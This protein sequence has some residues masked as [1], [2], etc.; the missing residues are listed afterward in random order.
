MDKGSRKSLKKRSLLWILGIILFINL[1]IV[2]T[3]N[4]HIYKAVFYNFADIDDNTIFYSRKVEAG[5]PIEWP[6]SKNYNKILM[7]SFLE[8]EHK[9]N[10]SVAFLIIKD[11]S[12]R[13]EKYWEGYD[14]NSLS[15]SFSMAKTIVSILVGIAIDEGKI[16]SLDEPV[17]NYLEEFK[18]GG[19]EVI[20]IRNLLTMSSGLNWDESYSNPFSVTTKAYYG[21]NLRKL[22]SKLE[23]IEDPGKV[24]KYLSGNSQILA[25]V[26]EKAT[27]MKLSKYASEKLW[28]P[29]GARNSA[30]WSL[31]KKEGEEKAYC[32]FYS[33]A[34]DFAKI[35]QLFLKKGNWYGQQMVSEQYVLESITPAALSQDDGTPNDYYGY[36][37]WIIPNY[38]NQKIYY[39]RGIL[40]QYIIVVPDKEMIIVRLGKNRGEKRG[41]HYSDLFSYIDGALE[42]YP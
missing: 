38:K 4:T 3:A 40:G 2:I 26:L 24:I 13:L 35:G 9:Q 30:E 32:C 20:T 36:A 37:W 16:K 10:E 29:L 8:E 5:N 41:N 42:M 23:K 25:F 11:D 1:I 33:N 6:L 14:E 22:I 27:G 12:I 28:K 21:N 19:K 31:D 34:R 39:A 7:P 17:A 15:N 18:G